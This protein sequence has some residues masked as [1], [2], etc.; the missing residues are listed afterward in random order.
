MSDAPR[1]DPAL[2]E[3]I[4]DEVLQILEGDDGTRTA[5]LQRVIEAHAEHAR[6]IRA[7]LTRAG[8]TVPGTSGA[9]TRPPGYDTLPT[10][11]G[12]YVLQDLLGRGG[13]GSVYRAEQHE[14]IRRPV[15][16]KVLNPGMDSR[17]VLARFAGE[18]EALNRMDHPGIAR[19]IDAGQTPQ[20]RPYFV[21][22]LV[23]GPTLASFCRTDELPVRAR[24]ELFLQVL[25]AT[26]HAHQKAVLHRDLSS[27]NVL[28]ADP[29]GRAQCKIIDFGIA[30]SLTDP[31]MQGGALTFQGTLM[32][33]PE[34][35]SPE[36]AAGSLGDIDTRAD[37]YALGV[38]LYE[39]L[40]DQLPIPGVVLRA[41]G[42]AGMAEVIAAHQ[43]TPPSEAAPP[44]RRAA[45]HGDLD[46][47]VMKAIA[48]AREERYATVGQFADDLRAHLAD[49][50]VQV[51]APTTWYRLRKFVR[52]H[53]A[54]SVAAVIVVCGL[55]VALGVLLWALHIKNDALAESEK[56]RDEIAARADAGFRLLANEERLH[57]AIAAAAKL[58]PPWP[59]NAAAFT[60]WL[61]THGTP[62][63][64]AR[65]QVHDTLATMAP[66]K[67]ASPDGKFADPVDQHLFAALERLAADLAA[68]TGDG[69][70]LARV[71]KKQQ[72]L[73]Q[74]VTPAARENEALWQRTIAE[75]RQGDGANGRDYR[76]A[77]IPVLPGLVP[78]GRDPHTGLF[79]FL[80]LASHERGL[81][82]PQRDATTGDLRVGAGTG[83]V[84][85]LLPAGMFRI[86]AFRDE[87]GLPQNDPDAADDEL[88]GQLVNLD[89]FLIGRTELTVG[90]WS[91]LA[92]RDVAGDE[93]LLPITGVDWREARDLLR[94]FDLDLPTEAQWEY[95]CRAGTTTPWSCGDVAHLPAHAWFGARPQATGLL[96]PNA[97]GLCD[98][99]GNVAEWCR[100]EKLPY[101]DVAPAPED[102]LRKSA[103]ATELAVRV[104]R[105]G[106]CY[107]GAVAARAAAREGRPATQRDSATGLRAIRPLRR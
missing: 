83:I 37:V 67:A 79:E 84:F 73:E 102:G 46:A 2:P 51:V 63:A 30:K 94:Q 11:L 80:D 100:D 26:Q 101:R 98:V 16:V 90:Q 69:G 105:G 42:L 76:G 54:Q 106:A 68:F 25:D 17:E 103:G 97:F 34:F 96:Q 60:G 107:Q 35:M 41:Q 44:S 71:R 47:I 75:I 14:P 77:Q 4:E 87:P 1:H 43:V 58:P 21:M 65:D 88:G 104:V 7:W 9:P 57:E 85:V 15:A 86:G 32:G 13:F 38:Q 56:Q 49:Q 93:A 5:A 48:K 36:Q 62:L 45:L 6:T 39:L 3:A 52:R 82:P 12:P 72:L 53:R 22:E 74:V 95:A 91:R 29:H 40:T 61:A 18:R 24:I 59:E 20:G 64:A 8:V 27:N 55:L 70:P 89:E 81:P 23:E 99:H 33:T 78:L 31:L 28:V 19:L 92:G 10:R 50:P 66:K